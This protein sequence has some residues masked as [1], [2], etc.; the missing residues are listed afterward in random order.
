MNAAS[1]V[2]SPVTDTLDVPGAHLY[3]EVRGNGPLIVLLGTPMN[4]DAF[5][6]L[7]D[8]L[9]VDHTV[10]TTDPRGIGRSPVDDPDASPTIATRADDIARLVAHVGARGPVT[11]LGSSGGA[12]TALGLAELRPDVVDTVIAHEP[13][14]TELLPD[15]EEL[16]ASREE[17]IRLW[18]AGDH[19]GSW[20]NFLVGAGIEMPE[21]IF[22][23]IFAHPNPQSVADTDYQNGHL[24]RPTTHWLPDLDALRGGAP[25]IVVGI[26]EAS[27]GQVCDRT[28]RAL[29]ERLGVEPTTFPGGHVGF[30]E[31]PTAFL[32]HLRALLPRPA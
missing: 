31:D 1:P 28:S 18:F 14:L 13:P 25:R 29:A 10:L 3:H 17:T 11:L 21:D 30:A 5:A 8:L 15:R 24:M 9:A 16:R 12:V 19:V 32:P 4:A 23:A 6:P 20:R 27:A 7:A 22:Q 26:G 2:V